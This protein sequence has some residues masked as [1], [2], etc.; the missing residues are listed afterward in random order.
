[1]GI[2]YSY[3]HDYMYPDIKTYHWLVY[4]SCE[5]NY[6]VNGVVHIMHEN[7]DFHKSDRFEHIVK[8]NIAQQL[9]DELKSLVN[10]ITVNYVYSLG[11]QTPESLDK[12]PIGTNRNVTYIV[13]YTKEKV[14]GIITVKLC[15]EHE[16]GK[17]SFY[18]KI[19]SLL[20]DEQVIITDISKCS[21]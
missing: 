9:P 13:K 6:T 19:K 12:L 10:H 14:N 15:Y 1:M 21:D 4:V 16:P 5:K 11:L 7:S 8:Y 3:Y 17:K 2:A 18:D 20:N